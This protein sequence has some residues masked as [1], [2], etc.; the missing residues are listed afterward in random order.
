[1]D[2][3]EEAQEKE[4]RR[5]H[6]QLT[7]KRLHDYRTFRS[8]KDQY[9][10]QFRR[11]EITGWALMDALLHLMAVYS[12]PDKG[13]EHVELMKILNK[14]FRLINVVSPVPMTEE[15]VMVKVG[16]INWDEYAA[17]FKGKFPDKPWRATGR[18]TK[19]IVNGLVAVANNRTVSF[20]AHTKDHAVHM[21]AL[22]Q[23]WAEIC[24]LRSELVHRD[25]C[26]CG[27]CQRFPDHNVY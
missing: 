20:T 5:N 19:I 13:T 23:E 4:D 22:A 14:E 2:P 3:K 27:V 18:T 9:L 6:P 25:N 12:W 17:M 7:G 11:Q 1:M 16:L 26:T 10:Q 24:D 21:T 15:A 8:K